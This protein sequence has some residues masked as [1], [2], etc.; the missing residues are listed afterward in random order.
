MRSES[1]KI[2]G[3]VCTLAL[4]LGAR[5]APAWAEDLAGDPDDAPPPE[6]VK[7]DDGASKVKL[8]VG[9]RLRSVFIPQGLIESF[10]ERAPSGMSNFG[11]GLE[12]TRRKGNFEIA[13][14]LEYEKLSLSG[15]GIW[16]DK[17]DQIPL[18]EPDLVEYDGFGWVG[19]DVS[20][21]WHT[22]LHDK[23]SL[24]Y[25]AGIGLGFILGDVL[26][27]DYLCTGSTVD[28][29]SQKPGAENI[30]AKDQDIPPV[31]P[32]INALFGVSIKATDQI[33]IN[34]EVGMRTA[35]YYG[36]TLVFYF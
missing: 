27:T 13:V 8:G 21:I 3:V 17:G 31:F 32:I 15:D 23:V 26:R 22:K 4:V 12:F 11:Y 24:R 2:L 25:G 14:G 6:E 9:L 1:G 29:C 10:V 20:F 36:T 33:G 16:I 30:K 35:F 34:L 18:D 19:L 28:T 5:S 7:S